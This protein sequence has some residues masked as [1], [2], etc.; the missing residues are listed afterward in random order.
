MLKNEKKFSVKT[1]LSEGSSQKG[2]IQLRITNYDGHTPNLLTF[3]TGYLFRGESG[4]CKIE[5]VVT[6]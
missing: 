4:Q 5:S 3:G 1:M 2:H 6:L